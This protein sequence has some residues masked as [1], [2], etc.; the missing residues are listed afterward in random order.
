MSFKQ[1]L[2]SHS[3]LYSQTPEKVRQRFYYDIPKL[4]MIPVFA[5][6]SAEKGQ[7]GNGSTGERITT[8]NKTAFDIETQP[9]QRT[10]ILFDSLTNYFISSLY[11]RN[12]WEEDC[13]NCLW[14]TTQLGAR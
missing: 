12:G 3:L 13:E 4:I 2:E 6:G 5:F 1:Q 11:Q 9:S 10:P 8:G 7:L 14:P